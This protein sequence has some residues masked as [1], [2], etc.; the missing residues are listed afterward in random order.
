MDNVLHFRQ[1]IHSFPLDIPEPA[2][3][4]TDNQ[5]FGDK[6]DLVT[7]PLPERDLCN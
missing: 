1:L 6:R 5:D 3:R 2:L 4:L 7:V